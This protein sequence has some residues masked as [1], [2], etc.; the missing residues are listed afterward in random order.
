MQGNICCM[1]SA[2]F[3]KRYIRLLSSVSGNIN[4]KTA[5][6]QFIVTKAIEI[7]TIVQM[8]PHTF[9]RSI[10]SNGNGLEIQGNIT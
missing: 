7:C 8:W 1:C 2:A 5:I 10:Y 6:S 3:T 9:I 4:Y